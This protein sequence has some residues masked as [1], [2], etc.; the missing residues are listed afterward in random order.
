MAKGFQTFA[1]RFTSL[2]DVAKRAMQKGAPTERHIDG[3]KHPVK[4]RTTPIVWGIPTDELGFSK[5]WTRFV[6]FANIMPW[7][8]YAFSE[9]TYLEKARN[10]IHNKFLKSELPYLMMLDSDIWFPPDMVELLMTHKLP[11]VGG[12]YRDKNAEDHHP[13]VYD[14]AEDREGLAIFRHRK[15]PGTGLERVEG[16]GA[17][18][19]LMTREVAQA[20]G[21]DPYGKNIAGGGE[22]MKLC[23]RLID[24]EIP[25]HVD[26]SI[27]CAHVGVGFW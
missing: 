18:C 21:E 13:T 9:G 15:E 2:G 7:D 4:I 22:D 19:W 11:I 10:S 8:S 23:R 17:G 1:K 5:F 24:L 25:L 14:F 6:R 16:M 20:L 26:W 12:W 27:N 3:E